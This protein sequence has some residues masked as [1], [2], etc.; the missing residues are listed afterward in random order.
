MMIHGISIGF[1]CSYQKAYK[2][3]LEVF[4]EAY[5]TM[6]RINWFGRFSANGYFDT[7]SAYALACGLDPKETN[8]EGNWVW[9]TK[10]Y[11]KNQMF[12]WL[13]CHGKLPTPAHL[14]HWGLEIPPDCSFCHFPLEDVDHILR[15]CP[16]ATSFWNKLGI[17]ASKKATFSFPAEDWFAGELWSLWKTFTRHALGNFICPICLG[18]VETKLRMDLFVLLRKKWELVVCSET[19]METGSRG[20]ATIWEHQIA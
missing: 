19:R 15:T 3:L 12:L 2:M 6:E 4:L 7:K 8:K 9:T 13:C 10:T 1:P 5:S 18:P 20:S 11:P 14:N 16:A 17:P